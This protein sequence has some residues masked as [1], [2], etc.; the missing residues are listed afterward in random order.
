MATQSKLE[1]ASR[2]GGH[3]HR[4]RALIA[5]LIMVVALGHK[6]IQGALHKH[7]HLERIRLNNR[8]KVKGLSLE[9][10]LEQLYVP[11]GDP[12][13]SVTLYVPDHGHL[14]KA[15][16]T[17]TPDAVYKLSLIHI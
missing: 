15:K 17:P 11:T 8:K 16:V 5:L 12:D 14:A 10:G 6:Q 3:S 9:E 4:S 7:V 13:G 2:I 1:A